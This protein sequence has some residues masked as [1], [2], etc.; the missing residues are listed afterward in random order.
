M[1]DHLHLPAPFN[2]GRQLCGELRRIRHVREYRI[3]RIRV[4]LVS[5]PDVRWEHLFETDR[6]LIRNRPASDP[7]ATERGE[8]GVKVIAEVVSSWL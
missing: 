3:L 7:I 5:P 2:D 6:R 4:G 8:D 1:D